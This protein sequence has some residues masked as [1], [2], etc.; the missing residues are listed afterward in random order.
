LIVLALLAATSAV[1]GENQSPRLLGKPSTLPR[2]II[3]TAVT[4]ERPVRS[5]PVEIATW[6]DVPDLPARINEV[7]W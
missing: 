2:E 1:A 5:V 4:R 7:L 6:P 3:R